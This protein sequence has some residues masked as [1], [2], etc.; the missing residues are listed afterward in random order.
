M[1]EGPAKAGA[2]PSGPALGAD[3][4]LTITRSFL[5]LGS[6]EAIARI[7]GFATTLV[8]AR[9]LGAEGLGVIA[10][11]TAV[12]LYFTRVVDAGFGK[13]IGVREA[14]ARRDALGDFIPTVLALRFILA[15]LV[16]GVAGT[17]AFFLLPEPENVVLAL[18]TLTLVPLA[19]GTH[20][21]LTGLDRT[22]TV[23]VART[24]GELFVLLL[25]VLWVRDISDVW[26]APIA[27][28]WGDLALAAITFLALRRSGLFRVF[29]LRPELV[30]SL[31]PHIVPYVG[32][33]LLGIVTFNADVLFLRVFRDATVV[34]FYSSAYAL[35]SFLINVGSAYAMSLL[36]S[37]ARV[38]D[39]QVVRQEV[40]DAAAARVY[41]SAI[42]IAVGGAL[43]AP[44]IIELT[45]GSAFGPAGPVLAF[46]LWSVP[47]SLL[48]SV[49]MTAI[50]SGKREDYVLRTVA[51]SAA[52]NLVLNLL[53]VPTFGML[54]AAGATVATE[55]LRMSLAVWHARKV[56]YAAPSIRRWRK[57]TVAVLVMAG[58]LLLGV[59]SHLWIALPTAAITYGVGLAVQGAIRIRGWRLPEVHV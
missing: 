18:Y 31:R 24:V 22:T 32:S 49:A 53:L 25:V 44:Q 26:R 51:A 10:F 2:A 48:T 17:A 27:Q 34:G 58:V 16:I 47:F 52:V 9:R 29:R 19:L 8:L 3:L 54:G 21:V 13:G 38:S 12:L 28:M 43:V 6:G 56:G 57:P 46:V 36:A 37:L 11:S 23:G 4:H 50:M 40:F 30:R 55:M 41:L 33:S 39:D 7:I 35:V 14:S 59:R 42:P 20:W 45:Y 1:T 5:S 15:V